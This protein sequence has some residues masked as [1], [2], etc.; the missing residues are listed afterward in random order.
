MSGGRWKKGVL[1]T[2]RHCPSD[3]T[4]VTVLVNAR[5]HALVA[6]PG[7]RWGQ[8]ASRLGAKSR[9][10]AASSSALHTQNSSIQRDASL[11]TL[12]CSSCHWRSLH[13][14]NAV[15]RLRAATYHESGSDSMRMKSLSMLTHDANCINSLRSGGTQVVRLPGSVEL[16]EL[17]LVAPELTRGGQGALLG[18][19][20][21]HR[22]LITSITLPIRSSFFVSDFASRIAVFGCIL[23]SLIAIT[24]VEENM[25]HWPC[26]FSASTTRA[27]KNAWSHCGNRMRTMRSRLSVFPISRFP[28][29]PIS[30]FPDFPTFLMCAPGFATA[31]SSPPPI[32]R[33]PRCALYTTTRVQSTLVTH[34]ARVRASPATHVLSHCNTRL[35]V[36]MQ[37]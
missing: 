36:N 3:V 21:G 28:D 2:L 10:R 16:A 9:P 12:V 15:A 5:E 22:S 20:N 34:A 25:Q 30:R 1:P 27:S 23:F 31:S 14:S 17:K 6:C 7:G 13:C 4:D 33:S 26:L 29:F 11:V 19:C 32:P 18:S 8:D 35:H 37:G 24:A